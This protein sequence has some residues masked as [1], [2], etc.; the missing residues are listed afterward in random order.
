SG[1][2]RYEWYVNNVKQSATG[3]SYS[4]HFPTSGTYTIKFKVVDLTMQNA[5][6]KWGA[7]SPV[8]KVY[9]KMVVSTSQSATSVS[10]S[11]ASVSFNV[12]SISGGSGSRQI[13]WRAFKAVSPS[14]TAGSGTGTQFSFSN[15][16]TGTHE[17]NITVTVKDNLTGKEVTRLMVV[18]SSIS[19]E[20]CP[21]CGPQH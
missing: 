6:T 18:V 15:F 2:R 8:L 3:T 11:S 21:N 17:Y 10:G 20:D 19:D 4:Y 13:T 9:P 1:S 16:A 12:T 7:N 14:Q 5:N